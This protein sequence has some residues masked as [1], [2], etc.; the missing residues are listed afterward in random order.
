MR[1]ELLYYYEQELAYVRRMGAAFAEKYPKVASRLRLEQAKCDDPHV[2]RLLEAFAFL[3][4][5][6]HLKLE[7]DFPEISDALLSIVYPHYLRPI[8]SM[9]IVEFQLD[10]EQGKVTSGFPIP[11]DALLY[12]RPAGGAPCKFRTCYDTTLWPLTVA[13]AQW[14]TP[15]QLKPAASVPNAA[16]AVRV[17][18]QC[19]PDVTFAK[20][21]LNTLR[22]FLNG[23]TTLVATL[24]EL[25]CN[26]CVQIQIRDTGP[27]PKRKPV[28]LPPAALRPVGFGP[29]EGMLP[30]PRRTMVAYRLLQEYFTFPEKF[31]FLDLDG[32]DQVRA[33][34]FG[35][36]A[37]VVFFLSPFERA[38]RRPT[39]EAGVSARTMLLGC[40]PIVN[41]FAQDSEPV[42]IVPTRFE[43]PV[44]A[45]ARR[46]ET[47]R[48]FSVE[49]VIAA[50]PGSPEVLRFE[51]LYSFRHGTNGAKAEVFWHAR[52]R[53]SAWGH[54][55]ETDVY[56]AFAD[57]SGR[58]ARP[59]AEAATCRLTCFNGDLPSRL[60]FDEEG[61]DFT[62]PGGAPIQRIVAVVKPTPAI[63]P[64]LGRPQLWRL[65]SQLS[66]N[67]LS[68]VEGGPEALQELLRL[69][70]F[71]DSL[72]GEKQIQG[73]LDV[74]SEPCYSRIA[75]EHGLSFARGH[76]V[77][78]TFDEEQFAGGG[79]YLFAS[80]LERFLGLYS[81]MNSF[82]V[83]AA[84]SRQRKE[85][86]REW[87]PRAGWKTLV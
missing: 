55:G 49:D 85:T 4:A 41:L 9:S 39:L 59:P 28:V 72:A 2:E 3:T 18:L 78:I 31:F 1:D 81:A 23:E 73:L 37:E 22:F 60:P 36:S 8:P 16:A 19:L 64:L 61:S 65:I 21:E 57:R 17:E 52:P 84:R 27:A 29:D 53:P 74:R 75:G 12:T 26:N 33:A 77:E 87:P 25:L 69:H 32:F 14:R 40:T 50:R 71:G 5:R 63:P 20:L 46:R 80:V 34:G 13:A 15:D 70:N 79:L 82:C 76:R 6:V 86:L 45:D 66:L 44:V 42:E 10:P 62:L 24:Y 54:A 68:L 58:P 43:H 56:L 30:L 35:P 67:Y 38:E 48:V 47:T 11:K 83:L 51:P 7:D